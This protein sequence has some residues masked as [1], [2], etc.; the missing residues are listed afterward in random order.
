M[1]LKVIASSSSGNG[2]IL[3]GKE[4]TLLLEAGVPVSI[5]RKKVDDFRTIVGCLVSHRHGDH[6]KYIADYIKAGIKVYALVDVYDSA[7][8]HHHI[9]QHNYI[10]PGGVHH[11]GGFSIYCCTARHDVPCLGFFIH[12]K[13]IGNLTFI[14]DSHDF[15]YSLE[16]VNHIMI[17]C[18]WSDEC[19]K[20]A[21]DEGR[22]PWFVA[23]RVRE[24]H[25]GL[26]DAVG[27]IRDEVSMDT[28]RE[29]VLLHLSH[30]NSDPALFTETMVN[31][32]HK[33]TF[34]ATDGLVVDL[35]R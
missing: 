32:F 30:E 27:Y 13:E 7:R 9:V 25:M 21:I 8:E 14:T 15:D 23:N 18:N 19:L 20:K 22:T 5:V 17:E 28:L 6:A 2:Y 35:N 34:V 26:H 31:E 4:E 11:L 16:G 24:T 33:P 1:K 12:H 10:E 3:Q 29:I